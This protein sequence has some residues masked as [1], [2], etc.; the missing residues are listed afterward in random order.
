MEVKQKNWMSRSE[1]IQE[2]QTGDL[3]SLEQKV[4]G[5]SA[6]P[7]DKPLIVRIESLFHLLQFLQ[8]KGKSV[9]EA[10]ESIRE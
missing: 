8:K 6:A 2:Q 9:D 4:F 1:G 10:L 5:S 3:S 7:E